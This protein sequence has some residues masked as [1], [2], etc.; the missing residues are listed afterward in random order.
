M[1]IDNNSC[2][3]QSVARNSQFP[4]TVSCHEQSVA[5]NSQLP[6]TVSCQEQ[7]V[8][9]NSQLPGTVSCHEQSVAMTSQL[10]Y[11]VSCQEQSV[12]RNSQLPGT[13]S[14]H[15]QSVARNSQ[16]LIGCSWGCD[17]R[18]QYLN[19]PIEIW[20][21]AVGAGCSCSW[22]LVAVGVVTKDNSILTNPLR[23]DW[24]QL[25]LWR[26]TTLS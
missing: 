19:Q 8:S 23:A 7:S 16:L 18:L 13:V 26:K 2:H 11:T 6:W 15:D 14:C 1:P 3:E 20:L 24:L 10:P 21:V 12:A 9:R 17:E 4:W 5:R 25:G 22:G